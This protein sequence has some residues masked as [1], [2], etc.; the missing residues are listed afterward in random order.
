MAKPQHVEKV[1]PVAPPPQA[2]TS[3]QTTETTQNSPPKV[4]YATDLFDMLSMD[5]PNEKGSGA[6][7]ATADDNNWAG[8]QCMLWASLFL[9][10]IFKIYHE[11][12]NESVSRH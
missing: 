4:D 8:F 6:A 11:S 1:E 9:F 3:K 12:T 5:D 10:F 2:E 7:D